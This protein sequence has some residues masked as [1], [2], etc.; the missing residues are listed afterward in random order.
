MSFIN[1][2]FIF[3]NLD[4]IFY[5]Q[6]CGIGNLFFK[7]YSECHLSSIYWTVH[8]VLPDLT[9]VTYQDNTQTVYSFFFI[10]N[11][12]NFCEKFC[13]EM[14][15]KN[16][17]LAGLRYKFK[18]FLFWLRKESWPLQLLHGHNCK[19]FLHGPTYYSLYMDH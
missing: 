1:L 18:S 17:M 16:G 4:F 6:F 3:I 9:L 19:T 8:F 13:W 14:E 11:M 12:D 15:R 10:W 5:S 7:N 2:D